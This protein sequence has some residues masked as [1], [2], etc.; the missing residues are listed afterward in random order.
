MLVAK[1]KPYAGQKYDMKVFRD[2]D[3]LELAPAIQAIL[4]EAGWAGVH[5]CCTREMQ[6]VTRETGW[7]LER[8]TYGHIIRLTRR[9]FGRR[10]FAN[11]G[12]ARQSEMPVDC[13][14]T[15]E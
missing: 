2:Q 8:L 12:N 6:Q 5:E 4:E 14:W 10:T 7:R 3:S 11:S 15:T 9:V 1:L 13:R